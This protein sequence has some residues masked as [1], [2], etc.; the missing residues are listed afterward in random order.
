M[1]FR[2]GM[3]CLAGVV[4]AVASLGASAQTAPSVTL[5]PPAKTEYQ[6]GETI[7]LSATVTDPDNDIF[8]VTFYPGVVTDWNGPTWTASWTPNSA[9]TFN[10]YARARDDSGLASN[11]NTIPITVVSTNSAPTVTLT[12]PTPNAVYVANGATA[13]VTLRANASDV[14]GNLSFVSFKVGNRSAGT[15][16]SAPFSGSIDLIPGTYQA[17]ARAVDSENADAQ[18]PSVTFRV[19]G[20]SPPPT[21]AAINVPGHNVNTNQFTVSWTASS[22]ATRYTLDES[23]D[24]GPWLIKYNSSG[25]STTITV[26]EDGTYQYRVRANNSAGYIGFRYSSNV[27]VKLPT[28]APATL[29][30]PDGSTTEYYGATGTCFDWAPV[31]GATHYNVQVGMTPDLLSS[32]WVR[33]DVTSTSACWDNGNGWV[34]SGSPLRPVS[35]YQGDGTR[36]WRVRALNGPTGSD[37]EF[38]L[39]D[40]VAYALSDTGEPLAPSS[41][42]VPTYNLNSVVFPVSWTASA[43]AEEYVVEISYNSLPETDPNY[44]TGWSSFGTYTTTTSLS[45]QVDVD[46][47]GAQN[48]FQMD[49][50]FRVRGRNPVGTSEPSP[51]SATVNVNLPSLPP[52]TLLDPAQGGTVF[53]D[54]VG[55]CFYW[56]E[57][58]P[59]EGVT[60]HV[61]QVWKNNGPNVQELPK[62]RIEVLGNY[63]CWNDGVGFES[64]A[65]ANGQPA[66]PLAEYKGNGTRY[67]RVRAVKESLDGSN[68][69]YSVSGVHSF[70]LTSV[71]APATI[72][73]P[74]YIVN[75]TEFDVSWDAASGAD[76]Y[77]LELSA[78]AG[79]SWQTVYEGPAEQTR[80]TVPDRGVYLLQVSAI[81]NLVASRPTVSTPV[82]VN[83][84]T[85]TP[86]TLL[87]PAD[88]GTAYYDESGNCFAWEAVPGA[89][90]YIVQV[91]KDFNAVPA[92]AQKWTQEL[93]STSVCW[94]DGANFVSSQ[95]PDGSLMPVED[96][97]GEGTR[98]WRVRALKGQLGE[99]GFE[100]SLSETSTYELGLVAPLPYSYH[101]LDENTAGDTP[102]VYAILD[103]TE[104]FFNGTTFTANA[105]ELIAIGAVARGD[106]IE[107]TQPLA[108]GSDS[109]GINMP[110]PAEFAGSEFVF[111]AGT[112]TSEYSVRSLSNEPLT[113]QYADGNQTF[114]LPLAAGE[115]V[116]FNSSGF[117]TQPVSPSTDLMV[118]DDASDLDFE[119]VFVY[120]LNFN[121]Q[122]LAPRVGDAQFVAAMPS[123]AINGVTIVNLGHYYPWPSGMNLGASADDQA[124]SQVFAGVVHAWPATTGAI[125]LAVEAGRRYRLQLLVSEGTP[126][127]GD[128]H[129]RIA[130]ENGLFEMD[131]AGSSAGGATFVPS[132]SQG[133]AYTMEFVATDDNLDIDF[134]NL[135]T[136]S[137]QTATISGLTLER[138]PSPGEAL[139]GQTALGSVPVQV[140]T[141]AAELDFE[142]TFNYAINFAG[143]G[144]NTI[145]DAVFSN[146]NAA[147][148]G[149]P[150]GM[151]ITGF[152]SNHYW[153]AAS[154]LGADANNNTLEAILRRIVWSNGIATGKVSLQTSPGTAYKLQLLFSEICCYNNRHFRVEVESPD[155]VTN[156]KAIGIA[157][158]TVWEGSTTQGYVIIYEFIADGGEIE[159]D[160]S[161]LA[162]GDS[163]YHISALTL[164]DVSGGS[165]GSSGESVVITEPGE[166]PVLIVTDASQLDFVGDIVY[167]LNFSGSGSS[168]IGDAAFR[169]VGI[170]GVGAPAGY[171]VSGFNA[172]GAWGGGINIGAGADNDALDAVLATLFWTQGNAQ[173][174]PAAVTLPVTPGETY[175][176]QFLTSENYAPMRWFHVQ[177]E[178]NTY[179]GEFK[180]T[181]YGAD[182]NI[183]KSS[184]R[185]YAMVVDF[186]AQD[187]TL[188][189]DFNRVGNAVGGYVLSGLTLE[190]IPAPE[191]AVGRSASITSVN[192]SILVSYG[193][194]AGGSAYP[195]PPVAQNL[196]GVATGTATV[197]AGFTDTTVGVLAS[198]ALA[199]GIDLAAA[200]FIDV[201]GAA[202]VQGSGAALGLSAPAS[203]AAIAENDGDGAGRIG[204]WPDSMLANRFVIPVDTQYVAIACVGPSSVVVNMLNNSG[205]VL[206]SKTCQPS[207]GAPGKAYF[208]SESNGLHIPAGTRIESDGLIFLAYES[209]VSN[210]ERNL[211]GAYSPV[212]A[213]VPDYNVNT[214]DFVVGWHGVQGAL[215]YTLEVSFNGGAWTT[216]YTGAAT[217][218]QVNVSQSGSYRYRVFATTQEGVVE[219]ATEAEVTVTL[220]TLPPAVLTSPTQD[221]LVWYGGTGN[222]FSWQAPDDLHNYTYI[223]Q[224]WDTP[225]ANL[226]E[227]PKWV[228]RDIQGTSVCWEDGVGWESSGGAAD[229][230]Q[231]RGDGTRYWRVR[232]LKGESGDPDFEFSLS[233]VASYELTLTQPLRHAYYFLDELHQGVT[234]VV[235][236]LIDG[237]RIKFGETEYTA[238]FG[239]LVP[240]GPVS[241][242]DVIESSHPLS[243][244]IAGNGMDMPVP[245]EF[246][247]R[248]FIIPQH[249]DGHWIYVASPTGEAVSFQF[250]DGHT[251]TAYDLQASEILR[252]W[253]NRNNIASYIYGAS[254]DILVTH[255]SSGD[256]DVFPVPPA[257]DDILG[258][259]S[260]WGYASAGH[261]GATVDAYASNG[262]TASYSLQAGEL[263]SVAGIEAGYG[264]ASAVRLQSVAGVGAASH[265][266][267][268]GGESAGFWP[269]AMMASRYILPLETDYVAIACTGTEPVY[270]QVIVPPSILINKTCTPADPIPG[271]ALLSNA[272]YVLPFPAGTKVLSTAPI[273]LYYDDK[274]H[275]DQRNLHGA[276]PEEA[277]ASI[278]VD[279]PGPYTVG[280]VLQL[281][282]NSPEGFRFWKYRLKVDG[283][284]IGDVLPSDPTFTWTATE[285]GEFT[286]T[287]YVIDDDYLEHPGEPLTVSVDPYVLPTPEWNSYPTVR[288]N[289]SPFTLSWHP[290]EGATSYSV[291][292][293]SDSQPAS[294][295]EVYFGSDTSFNAIISTSDFH[296]FYVIARDTSLGSTSEDSEPSETITIDYRVGGMVEPSPVSPVFGDEVYYADS[297][298][299]F[300]W[301]SVPDATHY[302]LQVAPTDKFL[303][304]KWV[305]R[306]VPN[307]PG[308]TSACWNDGTTFSAESVTGT[309]VPTSE[310][311]SEGVKY[312]R[313]RAMNAPSGSNTDF[314]LIDP[315][316][317]FLLRILD[318]P[319]SA[320]VTP[321]ISE[322]GRFWISWSYP[323]ANLH[324]FFIEAFE[325][326]EWTQVREI[327]AGASL[328]EEFVRSYA[329]DYL[330]RIKA[331]LAGRPEACSDWTELTA[332]VREPVGGLSTL[333]NVS[334]TPLSSNGSTFMLS[335]SHPQQNEGL[336]YHIYELVD[337]EWSTTPIVTTDRHIQ[338]VRQTFGDYSYRVQACET[339]GSNCSLYSPPQQAVVTDPGSNPIVSINGA[340]QPEIDP[341]VTLSEASDGVGAIAGSFSVSPTGSAIYDIPFAYAP[342]V[343]G[344]APQL[345][346]RYSSNSGNGIAGKGAFIA[347]LSSI[348]RCRQTL[349]YDSE[350]VPISFSANDRYCLDGQ[351]LIHVSGSG[352]ESSPM[353]GDRYR[354]AIDSYR[355]ITIHGSESGEGH[356]TYFTVEA[357]DGSVSHYGQYG[358]N[359]GREKVLHPDSDSLVEDMAISWKLSRFEDN[360]GNAIVYEYDSSGRYLDA[361]RY[362]YSNGTPAAGIEFSYA[363]R[364]DEIDSF[365]GGYKIATTKRLK[366]IESYN[367]DSR[368]GRQT[369]RTYALQY[370]DEASS[371]TPGGVSRLASLEEC[372]IGACYPSTEFSWTE[373]S[374]GEP[375]FLRRN[376]SSAAISGNYTDN[377]P[378]DINADGYTD[379]LWLSVN[380]GGDQAEIHSTLWVPPANKTEDGEYVHVTCNGCDGTTHFRVDELAR[381]TWRP[382]DFNGDG[383]TDVAYVDRDTKKLHVRFAQ[384]GTT[385]A[386]FSW[387]AAYNTGIDIRVS[388]ENSIAFADFT[389]D[390]L[391]D[392]LYE[393]KTGSPAIRLMER[394]PNPELCPT[395]WPA[396][397]SCGYRMRSSS[398]ALTVELI[399]ADGSSRFPDQVIEENFVASDFNGDGRVD[400]LVERDEQVLICQRHTPGG[401]ET[402]E[403]GVA[404]QYTVYRAELQTSSTMRFGAFFDVEIGANSTPRPESMRVADFNGDGLTDVLFKS[405]RYTSTWSFQT[406]DGASFAPAHVLGNLTESEV[407]SMQFADIDRDG[408]TDIIVTANSGGDFGTA[409]LDVFYWDQSGQVFSA[410]TLLEDGIS[411]H[412]ERKHYFYDVNGD[413]RADWV[414]FIQDSLVDEVWVGMATDRFV[415]HDRVRRIRNGLGHET[416]IG[417]A[418]ANDPDYQGQG[419]T[420][421][422]YTRGSAAN[423]E[424][425]GL[426]AEDEILESRA[427]RPPTY[428]IRPGAYMVRWVCSSLPVTNGIGTCDEPDAAGGGASYTNLSLQ[429]YKYAGAVMQGSGRGFLGFASVEVT[430]LHSGMRTETRYRQDYPFIGRPRTVRQ[431]Y[432][433]GE[434]LLTETTN[435]HGLAANGGLDARVRNTYVKRSYQSSYDPGPGGTR[436]SL[437]VVDNQG[438]STPGWDDW[439]NLAYSQA[440]YHTGASDS[441]FNTITTLNTFG[442]DEDA[443]RLG[444]LSR[445]EVTHARTNES[446]V[447]RISTFTY[448]ADNLLETETLSWDS[449]GDG[450]SQRQLVTRHGYDAAGNKTQIATEGYADAEDTDFQQRVAEW[451]YDPAT[452]RF[453][454]L[455][456]VKL[457]DTM[458]V[459]RQILGR[460]IRNGL[461]IRERDINGVETFRVYGSLDRLVHEYSSTGDSRTM[462]YSSDTSMC[463]PGAPA[464]FSVRTELGSGRGLL[465]CYDL[466]ERELR[467]S[468]LGFDGVYDAVDS[469]YD[470]QGRLVKE[471][472]PH[473]GST[474]SA[475]DTVYDEFG[476]VEQVTQPTGAVT[477]YTYAQ[478]TVSIALTADG[479]TQSRSQTRNGKGELVQ[480]TDD[481][482]TITY[483]YD[484]AG[485]LRRTSV[486]T[487]NAVETTMSYDDLGRKIGM[488]DR[489]K[490]TWA[491]KYNDFGELVRQSSSLGYTVFT[492]DEAGRQ[493]YREDFDPNDFSKSTTQWV[494][495]SIGNSRTQ[496]GS[497]MRVIHQDRYDLVADKV[498]NF[499][500]D[501]FGRLSRTETDITGLETVT[502]YRTYDEYGRTFQM[503]GGAEAFRG[504]EYD[505]NEFGFLKQVLDSASSGGS[506]RTW[507]TVESVDH[508]GNQAQIRLHTG[509]NETTVKRTY[510]GDTGLLD[511]I[512]AI[513]ATGIHQRKD[514]TQNAFRNIEVVDDQARSK[515]FRYEYDSLNRLRKE[516]VDGVAEEFG[517]DL[518]GN[519]KTRG[520]LTYNYNDANRPHA[521]ESLSDSTV[522]EYDG[523]GNMKEDGTRTLK[524]T[525]F[526][527][528]Y[529]VTRS[530]N[531]NSLL[532]AYGADRLRYKQVAQ[533]G[534]QTT[535]TYYLQGLEVVHRGSQWEYRRSIDGVAQETLE[536][537]EVQQ[538]VDTRISFFIRDHLGSIDVVLNENGINEE[539]MDVAYS[540]WGERRNP[541]T[542]ASLVEFPDLN[543]QYLRDITH[544]GFTGHEM[545]DAFGLIHMNG[546][547]YDPKLGRFLSADPIVQAPL[548]TQ[549]FNRYS[550][551]WN[552]P[553]TL[554]DPSGYSA[555]EYGNRSILIEGNVW[556][557]PVRDNFVDRFSIPYSPFQPGIDSPGSPPLSDHMDPSGVVHGAFGYGAVT[558]QAGSPFLVQTSIGPGLIGEAN[559][560]WMFD[561]TYSELTG[562]K[563]WSGVGSDSMFAARF[564]QSTE[565]EADEVPLSSSLGIA[566]AFITGS[567]LSSTAARYRFLSGDG[568]RWRGKNWK[569]NRIGWG[570]NQSTGRRTE[571][572]RR[573]RR[574][575][576]AGIGF[577]G[578]GT[579]L[580]VYQGYDASQR[581]DV[582]GAAIAGVDVAYGS[583]ATFGGTPGFLASLPYFGASLLVNIPSV[584]RVTVEP[585]AEG[586]CRI[587]GD[588]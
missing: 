29:V 469:S 299:C 70:T 330:F 123:T 420:A 198:E 284:A 536:K 510:T 187:E 539:Q 8:N 323:Q 486:A 245:I 557:Y 108:I 523:N 552:N 285:Q 36:Y 370:V 312:W 282:I 516:T 581:G 142:G 199:P 422:F 324:D 381:K 40:T 140:F 568:T 301:S 16:S 531:S 532:F 84:P 98:Y 128:R 394:N 372:G 579:V 341:G 173:Y 58:A 136:L 202:G 52:V 258:I 453:L 440:R 414:E 364:P 117:P 261:G 587:S 251:D 232:T 234:P 326:G 337:G 179:W 405:N 515:E 114:E 476:R 584:R 345:G 157:G 91:W 43:G 237:A 437:V 415:A 377:I 226:Q 19:D 248:D 64:V 133:Y 522:F 544:R 454:E 112:G 169:N 573:A 390:G 574:I 533:V 388:E 540:P 6:F 121:N 375:G 113:L 178:G 41:V 172:D 204:F 304:A 10:V 171:T 278:A 549:S 223:V 83:L 125:D 46:A 93:S 5:N 201:D 287:P 89:D 322:D 498:E 362:A 193:D 564:G 500:Y 80:V 213:F 472:I 250:F 143:L 62:W 363:D 402:C 347:G 398:T 264:G 483:T 180:G 358:G 233:A 356:P 87:D 580:S 224:V 392:I 352:T 303:D 7:H 1:G 24:G 292:R 236:S 163:N 56:Q 553:L 396:G 571:M 277:I 45:T 518:N 441:A 131:A 247:G 81:E 382:V 502:Q 410:R 567:G 438:G 14:D 333:G 572:L 369:L 513:N 27:T 353:D 391:P 448:N 111:P 487:Q 109:G 340:P 11:S 228:R 348:S 467:A 174:S 451:R 306:N 212:P 541:V 475:T 88:G 146:V 262:D 421:D 497:L 401:E 367:V 30:S 252:L 13:R 104:V 445:A 215:S 208:G 25:T 150:A 49:Y 116:A 164:E 37:T 291:Y 289:T 17:Y 246:A 317:S 403:V 535:T 254:A 295:T 492:Y 346:L 155:Y 286:I 170:S 444:R 360:M 528:P 297:G 408:Y 478:N 558:S 547:V 378:A 342:G 427:Q 42:T 517:Y 385:T 308:T 585:I 588:C 449:G 79:A 196:T 2:D 270:I 279:L 35:E 331:C 313:V 425:W 386:D 266:D 354:T 92:E 211:A 426:S 192:G 548:Y 407:N 72:T 220:P 387:S 569:W 48:L 159:I 463:P 316:E 525:V 106:I 538:V 158:D 73:V 229:V 452:L 263:V 242:G 404:R 319:S 120:A 379:F 66:V 575:Q 446:P 86:A 309:A 259:R 274:L 15:D 275:G 416:T 327:L 546:R 526:D 554:I 165:A 144:A 409:N 556:Q 39:S 366:G 376:A 578:V 122:G 563:Y 235:Y 195:V 273:Y 185:G 530:D 34:A 357:K 527:K 175:R 351:R 481:G 188:N 320:D 419:G 355:R 3:A 501:R 537:N 442:G 94:N 344:V 132:A 31:P 241:Q 310:F 512:E 485:N 32:R 436:T 506:R 494:F 380:G 325:E 576:A 413:G 110:V 216:A 431:V 166:V 71:D 126:S 22:G 271:R 268:N 257:S 406:S 77:K 55:N 461:P 560:A 491:Y 462:R 521:V 430:D 269:V 400:L 51:V 488:V 318:A 44:A 59:E 260:R 154:D 368:E 194:G 63:A 395:G 339:G 272:D 210:D 85:L 152:N 218:A 99:E 509:D 96:Y 457:G 545:L 334:Y 290:V 459:T 134:S 103:G 97:R 471:T 200:T 149:A 280:D 294:P 57:L 61:L 206:E 160:F 534:G 343:A 138:I 350:A 464:A 434:K 186:T 332:Q 107:S 153:N 219:V 450:N 255:R 214:N 566:G 504:V 90:R 281:T 298:P 499:H 105:G 197:S 447:T 424:R 156:I 383:A 75:V 482:G 439:G 161:R 50:R 393:P 227:L 399:E 182:G 465:A 374:V 338:L 511:A 490:G 60:S 365:V 33:Y 127:P 28:L 455:E 162:G 577:Y 418:S 82:T 221:E 276:I 151:S 47:Y 384:P 417:Y 38:S 559:L 474:N 190:R 508:W 222:C 524:Y 321:A 293:T 181:D 329:G 582:A 145:G 183:I 456:L 583:L 207:A 389:A 561:T 328:E 26:T 102:N 177:V 244:G 217:T 130:V 542:P 315:P 479:E 18:T 570:G 305:L 68:S 411:A 176:L 148:S 203:I 205:G 466:L 12:S 432:G 115:L 209:S 460:D 137:S 373:E 141:D 507:Y 100:F 443:R 519:L 493:V 495:D 4:F 428:D 505:Y 529:E 300:E 302:N 191:P 184:A 20:I 9:G 101:F 67:W 520:G 95:A 253:S 489:D 225:G 167:A 470:Q 412:A 118:V 240:I 65:G 423:E 76:S 267:G 23:K 168:V 562:G 265:R 239:E 433:P 484:A 147:G 256:R 480:A 53:Y 543:V 349:Q 129:F 435:V 243:I 311:N 503:F 565:L 54:S 249:R 119:G 135:G 296:Y 238:N 139:L 397:V 189:I 468:V 74:E 231:Y 514:V 551:V 307:T 496:P 78:D 314:S 550:Y 473:R 124:L 477:A 371:F 288:L 458:T 359:D 21:P 69:Q 230:S 335:W 283:E 429:T 586:I 555:G 336:E 361:V